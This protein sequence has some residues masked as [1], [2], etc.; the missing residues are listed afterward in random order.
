MPGVRTTSRPIL[1]R[2]TAKLGEI[3]ARLGNRVR[4][5]QLL[6]Q[7]LA[8]DPGPAPLRAAAERWRKACAEGDSSPLPKKAIPT[9][10]QP[11][12]LLEEKGNR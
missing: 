7:A 8:R 10:P 3:E 1:P 4:A 5:V 2:R 9:V 11:D 12:E 6:D